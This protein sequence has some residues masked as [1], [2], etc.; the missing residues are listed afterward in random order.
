MF[1]VIK[2]LRP[3][4]WFKLKSQNQHQNYKLLD[5]IMSGTQGCVYDGI[6]QVN[7]QEGVIKVVKDL[8]NWHENEINFY[9]KNINHFNI[10]KYQNV[11]KKYNDLYIVMP[12]YEMDL[13]TLYETYDLNEFFIKSIIKQLAL[14]I[15]YI[16]NNYNIYHP[17]IKME[18]ILIDK[19]FKNI[20]LTDFSV[21]FSFGFFQNELLI[22]P[23]GTEYYNPPEFRHNIFY[24]NSNIWNIGSMIFIILFNQGPICFEEKTLKSFINSSQK[25]S[26]ELKNF[27]LLTLEFDPKKRINIDELLV[28]EWLNT[29]SKY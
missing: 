6:D 17:D 26:D 19:S 25:I 13:H 11:Y 10:I 24:K 5:K 14:G 3:F 23:C 16:Q 27:L 20:V 2:R 12:K 29:E 7:N 1:K 18:N 9:M 4:E 15:K 28:H 8:E 21:Y 22:P